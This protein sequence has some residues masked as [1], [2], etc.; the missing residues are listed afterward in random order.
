MISALAIIALLQQGVFQGATTPPSGDT[1]GYWQ[2][3][4]KYSIVATLDEGRTA[5]HS[6]AVL[7]YVNNSPDTLREMYFHQYLN[8]FRPGSRWSDADARENRV[9]F[10]NLADPYYGYERLT[11]APVVDGVPVI[12]DYP[13]S[14]DSTV[15]HFRLP[16]PLRPHEVAHVSFEWDARPS[17]VPRRQGRR[18]RTW[19]FAQWYPKVAVYDRAGWEPNALVPAGE[20]YGEYGTYDV[21]LVVR[22]DQILGATGVPV[23][24]DPGWVR[25][26]KWGS[27][28]PNADAYG[29]PSAPEL[30]AAVPP[31]Y[32]AVRFLAENVHHFAWSASP[33]YRYEGGVY[34]RTVPHVRFPIWDT[35]AVNVLYKPGDDSTWGGGRAIE[36]T[37]TALKWLESIWGPYAYPQMTNLHRIEG[38]GTEFPM[39]VMNGSASQ[40]LILHEVGHNFTYGILGNNEWRSG[41]MDEGFTSFQTAWAEGILPEERASSGNVPLPPLLTPGYRVNA[42][43]IPAA[44]STD[45]FQWQ[46]ELTGHAQPI[47][48]NSADFSEFG[49]YN[50][51]IYERAQLMYAHLRDVLGDS[52]MHVFM[53]DYYMRWALKH[54][55]ERAMRASAERAYGKSLGWFFDEWVHGTGLLDYALGPVTTTHDARGWVTRAEVIRRGELRHPMPVGV[56]M[57]DGKWLLGRGDPLVD[58]Q[59]VEIVSPEQPTKV[60]LDP[61]HYT[62]DWDWRNNV[63]SA[64][65][66]TLP[67][68][69]TTFDWP[70]LNQSDR[71][72][73]MVALSPVAWYSDPQGLT[74]GIRAR[75]NYM[76]FVDRHDGGIAVSAR[77]PISAGGRGLRNIDRLQLWARMENL[78]LP[79]RDRPLMGVRVAG[80]LLDGIVKLD[81]SKSW[82]LSPFLFNPG[83]RIRATAYVTGA[84]PTDSLLLP[85]QWSDRGVTEVGGTASYRTK[86]DADSQ[87]V[88]LRGAVAGGTSLGAGVWSGSSTAYVRAEASATSATSIIGADRMLRVRLYGGVAP[89]APRQRGI[90]ASSADPFT[91]FDDNWFR[92]RGAVLKQENV[93]FLP[94]GGAALRGFSPYLALDKVGAANG[95]LSQRLVSAR[96]DWGRG[97]LWVAAFGDAGLASA[98][99]DSLSNALLADAGAGLQA[100]GRLY[101]RDLS[102]RLDFPLFVNQT[103]FAAWSSHGRGSVAMR[104][105]VSVGEIW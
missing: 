63:R 79:W 87:Y 19:D 26:T 91:T 15:M 104:W 103:G 60:E 93:N 61:L 77:A 21:T 94:I 88:Q 28:H 89:N 36:R 44:D 95:E 98:T 68:A 90:Y 105:V 71:R 49:I 46:L 34:V 37:I 96:G 65:L 59:V 27:P 72:H 99:G 92:P 38:G 64:R 35:V 102:V 80:A 25:V 4:I 23:S 43:T 67:A 1:I 83:P 45:L 86:V 62:W 40:G 2:Q 13:L 30:T 6:R 16:T 101:D 81:A 54:V 20:L 42:V 51:M 100:A 10:Q 52:A 3:G 11:S 18:G 17:L 57:P 78:Y 47:G 82:D 48:T 53:H 84:Y 31:G 56:R 29:T 41:W 69:R 33:D 32:R 5:L 58:D 75:T 50:F 76:T 74:L 39:M 55:D 97:S 7:T 8:A 14:P 9:R 66:G 22:D 24:G 70:F 73:T 12:I 85:E